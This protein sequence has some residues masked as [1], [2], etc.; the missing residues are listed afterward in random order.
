MAEI[1][2]DFHSTCKIL[3]NE[4]CKNCTQ[5]NSIDRNGYYWCNHHKKSFKIGESSFNCPLGLQ[6]SNFTQNELRQNIREDHHSNCENLDNENCINCTQANS[7]DGKGYYWCK[8]HNKSFK[9]S[10]KEPLTVSYSCISCPKANPIDG[11][12]KVWCRYFKKTFLLE[13]S[14]AEKPDPE[15]WAAMSMDEKLEHITIQ[16]NNEQKKY[17]IEMTELI[18]KKEHIVKYFNGKDPNTVLADFDKRRN[19]VMALISNKNIVSDSDKIEADILKDFLHH[20]DDPLKY[21]K[22]QYSRLSDIYKYYEVQYEMCLNDLKI[23]NTEYNFIREKAILYMQKIKEIIAELPLKDRTAFDKLDDQNFEQGLLNNKSIQEVFNEIKRLDFLYNEQFKNSVNKTAESIKSIIKNTNDYIKKEKNNANFSDKNKRIAT[24]IGIGL[25][26]FSI[27]GSV[28]DQSIKAKNKTN[29]SIVMLAEN[30]IKLRQGISDIEK[31]NRPKVE[32]FIK[33]ENELNHSL[34]E[35]IEKYVIIFNNVNSYIFPDGDMSK[36]KEA[37][38]KRKEEGGE[39]FTS[40]EFMKI[41]ELREFNKFLGIL[42]D[43]DL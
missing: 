29:E 20:K 11:E 35:S 17:E 18:E 5:A 10:E 25:A 23:V 13:E 12:K 24:G 40:D 36:T 8:Y 16:Y 27:A 34:N 31:T 32:E 9:M 21:A 19:E 2:A 3:D 43:A 28:I 1:K 42:V 14:E 37:R 33:R 6:T 26:A 7:I 22:A 38:R 4:N 15:K 30:E 39:Y 41:M